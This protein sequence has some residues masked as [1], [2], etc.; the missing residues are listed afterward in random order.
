MSEK[1]STQ[2][3]TVV[4]FNPLKVSISHED[5]IISLLNRDYIRGLTL[6]GGEPMEPSNQKGILPLVKRFKETYPKYLFLFSTTGIPVR[7]YLFI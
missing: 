7:E 5:E 6:L 2:K 4:T 1:K 3:K